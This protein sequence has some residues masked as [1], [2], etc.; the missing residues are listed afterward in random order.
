MISGAPAYQERIFSGV[1][2]LM[3]DPQNENI[4]LGAFLMD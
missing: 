1:L 2:G 4:G 3:E